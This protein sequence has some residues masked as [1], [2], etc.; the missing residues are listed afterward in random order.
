MLRI[1]ELIV[2]VADLAEAE[3][4]VLRGVVREEAGRLKSAVGAVA[5]G[6][7]FLVV[8]APLLMIG[9][10]LASWSV[11]LALEPAIGRAAAA[12]VAG[13]VTL[14]AGGGCLWIFKLH[15]RP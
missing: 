3:G 9:V 5:V 10:V 4:R 13:I 8:A 14:A 6:I 1:A 11:M 12:A 2:K 7:V 15:F